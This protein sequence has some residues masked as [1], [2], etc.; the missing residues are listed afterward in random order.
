MPC[1]P[2]GIKG[3]HKLNK[4]DLIS[5]AIHTP[6]E[7]HIRDRHAGRPRQNPRQLGR[8]EVAG[9]LGVTCLLGAYVYFR[10]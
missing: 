1:T 6:Q 5:G 2:A 8:K 10:G 7:S 4:S 9:S 3:F